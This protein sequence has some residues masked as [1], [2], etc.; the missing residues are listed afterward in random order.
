MLHGSRMTPRQFKQNLGSVQNSGVAVACCGSGPHLN[1]PPASPFS[2]PKLTAS[3]GL[4]VQLAPRCVQPPNGTRQSTGSTV[5]RASGSENREQGR[6]PGRSEMTSLY[7]KRTNIRFEHMFSVLYK[8][9]AHSA[10]RRTCRMAP[11]PQK[12]RGHTINLV[13]IRHVPSCK[14][15]LKL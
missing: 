2:G 13:Q 1:A 3:S 12:H 15:A 4:L 11:D 14:W 10:S 7:I 6:H 8:I 9:A 5:L